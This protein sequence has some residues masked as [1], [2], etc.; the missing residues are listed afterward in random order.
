VLRSDGDDPSNDEVTMRFRRQHVGYSNR[1]LDVDLR[2]PKEL[3]PRL[4]PTSTALLVIDI[5]QGMLIAPLAP[6]DPGRLV[7]NAAA[8]SRRFHDAGGTV[9]LARLTAR[10]PAPF[11]GG[12][13]DP[14]NEGLPSDWADLPSGIDP[15]SANLVLNHPRWNAFTGSCLATALRSRGVTTLVLSGIA[16]NVAVE[17]TARDA[18]LRGYQVIVAHDAV[19]A[20]DAVLHT[21]SL[22]KVLS[23]FAMVAS[24]KTILRRVEAR[25][26]R[27]Y[28]VAAHL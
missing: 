17:F 25:D 28:P 2:M 5:Q 12:L 9:I 20:R 13:I 23:Q 7:D 16:T 27:E 14:S 26:E 22:E 10:V 19:S 8:L 4:N 18:R 1:M 21:F 11:S 24:T 6:H 15:A 3:G